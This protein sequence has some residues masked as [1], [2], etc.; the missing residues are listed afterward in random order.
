MAYPSQAT[1][2]QLAEMNHCEFIPT[3]DCYYHSSAQNMPFFDDFNS[4]CCFA[5]SELYIKS[6]GN[7]EKIKNLSEG[8]IQSVI[9]KQAIFTNGFNFLNSTKMLS[10]QSVKISSF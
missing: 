4:G 10:T 7:I 1:L 2:H 6:N 8:E 9:R 5:L 3:P